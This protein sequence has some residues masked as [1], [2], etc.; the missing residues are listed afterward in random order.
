MIVFMSELWQRIKF[1]R[2]QVGLSQEKLGDLCDPP[3]SKSA[4]GQWESPEKGK[5]TTPKY[6][7]LISVSIS[8]GAS[9]EWLLSEASILDLSQMLKTQNSHE[10]TSKKIHKG[11]SHIEKALYETNYVLTNKDIDFIITYI[12]TKSKIEKNNQ[13]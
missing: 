7:N 6:E 10:L 2:K 3:V 11:I 9:L 4:V 13:N 8:T 5:R 1:A 12:A